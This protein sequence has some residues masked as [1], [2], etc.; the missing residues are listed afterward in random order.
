MSTTLGSTNTGYA[1]SS[2]DNPI[3]VP[4]GVTV[5]GPGPGAI[6]V[7]GSSGN[8][9]NQGSVIGS[10]AGIYMAAGGTVDNGSGG[11]IQGSAAAAVS[12]TGGPGTVQ[13]EAGASIFAGGGAPGVGVTLDTGSVYNAGTIYATKQGATGVTIAHDGTVI[14]AAGG[15]IVGGVAIGSGIGY[16]SNA[17]SVVLAS[18][19]ISLGGGGT[20]VN[21]GTISYQTEYGS[22]AAI[23][24]GG[25][26]LNRLTLYPGEVITGGIAQ[27]SSTATNTLELAAGATLGSLSGLA[28]GFVGFQTLDV[29]ANAAWMLSGTNV[30]ET[31]V[32][33]GTL[34][35][36]SS[37]SLA[38][39]GP[40]TADA[41]QSGSLSLQSGA[42]L[43]L[44]SAVGAGE[45]AALGGSNRLVLEDTA[46]F[47]GSIQG[48]DTS[49]SLDLSTLKYAA[50]STASYNSSTEIL[51]VSSGGTTATVGS[52]AL[53]SG[54]DPNAYSFVTSADPSGVGTD[55]RLVPNV[56]DTLA[57]T[58]PPTLAFD[59][60]VSFSSPTSVTFTGTVSDNAGVASVVL[61][62][63]AETLGLATLNGD[64]TWS[65]TTHL[66]R[67]FHGGF[68]AVATDTSGNSA[69]APS[70]FDLTTGVKSPIP[71][72]PYTAI[73]DRYDASGNSLG[74]TFFKH[75][76]AV[77]FSSS[78]TALPH[79]GSAYAYSGGS[80]FRGLPYAS[81]TDLYA[82]A[83]G[84][85][86]V[87][88]LDNTDGTHMITAEKNGVALHSIGSD[89]MIGSGSNTRF[90]FSAG[91][92]QDTIANFVIGGPGH[93]TLV[94]PSTDMARLAHSIA[95]A[96]T[97]HGDT[98]INLGHQDTITLQNVSVA[99]LKAHPGDFKF[100]A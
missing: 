71:D 2:P 60:S 7:S 40:L 82:P 28:T 73:Q 23:Y 62:E 45:V 90:V 22:E 56:T 92:G 14:N 3:I 32:N 9:N 54:L 52:L 11:R 55:V 21:S 83:G 79:G 19:N 27:A 93:D 95:S 78:Y 100:H 38:V 20:V 50:G 41:G 87:E 49:D 65:F 63:G 98:T 37:G 58:T 91:F 43:D 77:L 76:G 72:Q 36:Q 94:L 25:S 66:A 96:H 70:N 48:F 6:T 18:T 85:A 67:G 10:T 84:Q 35:I 75:N 16:F 17:G 68:S 29:D 39:T 30:A 13:N 74:Q 34:I 53:K 51:T 97:V 44:A 88:I 31:V 86:V 5:S 46:D 47:A 61:F 26:G 99:E 8:V 64:G 4:S 12:I 42:A 80:Y 59:P 24:L 81:F 33:D 89:T 15:Q 1:T 57:D 69:S